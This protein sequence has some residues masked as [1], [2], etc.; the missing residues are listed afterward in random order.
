MKYLELT[1]TELGYLLTSKT[2]CPAPV[3]VPSSDESGAT[4]LPFF[5][6]HVDPDL[7]FCPA[8]ELAQLA[9]PVMYSCQCDEV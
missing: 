7:P 5:E 3:L 9:L 1:D 4:L 6:I 8:C 2:S